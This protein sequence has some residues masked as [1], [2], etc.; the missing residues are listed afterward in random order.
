MVVA[1][2]VGRGGLRAAPRCTPPRTLS[3]IRGFL[4]IPCPAMSSCNSATASCPVQSINTC[5]DFAVDAP[6]ANSFGL[7]AECSDPGFD[8]TQATAPSIPAHAEFAERPPRSINILDTVAHIAEQALRDGALPMGVYG[9]VGGIA[10][11][12]VCGTATMSIPLLGPA[13]TMEAAPVCF[14]LGVGLGTATARL[15]TNLANQKEDPSAGVSQAFWV[16]ATAAAMG[17]ATP[18]LPAA[19]PLLQRMAHSFAAATTTGVSGDMIGT[20]IAEKSFDAGLRRGTDPTVW[21]GNAGMGLL[22]AGASEIAKAVFKTLLGSRAAAA[23]AAETL[24]TT[25]AQ[26]HAQP[27]TQTH[28]QPTIVPPVERPV[29]QEREWVA[30]GGASPTDP[31]ESF[32]PPWTRRDP[33]A[34]R[35]RPALQAIDESAPVSITGESQVA[36]PAIPGIRIPDDI[37]HFDMLTV[38]MVMAIERFQPQG[39]TGVEWQSFAGRL[40]GRIDGLM[41]EIQNT[42]PGSDDFLRRNVMLELFVNARK[43][44][45][46][47][48]VAPREFTAPEGFKWMQDLTGDEWMRR[49][50]DVNDLARKALR[51]VNERLEKTG[52]AAPIIELLAAKN[53][54]SMC[55]RYVSMAENRF[56]S[57][58]SEI[59]VSAP[60]HVEEIAMGVRAEYYEEGMALFTSVEKNSGSQAELNQFLSGLADLVTRAEA[61]KNILIKEPLTDGRALRKIADMLRPEFAKGMQIA[62]QNGWAIE[63]SLPPAPRTPGLTVMTFD[64]TP[65]LFSPGPL[66]GAPRTTPGSSSAV[67]TLKE[68]RDNVKWDSKA[69]ARLLGIPEPMYLNAEKNPQ[70]F[71]DKLKEW[72]PKLLELKPGDAPPPEVAP[73]IVNKAPTQAR[74][75]SK[76]EPKPKSEPDPNWMTPR[77]KPVKEARPTSGPFQA[78]TEADLAGMPAWTAGDV[79]DTLGGM[80]YEIK[81]QGN[82]YKIY[83]PGQSA[84]GIL[85]AREGSDSVVSKADVAKAL[86]G[87]KLKA[88]EILPLPLPKL[89]E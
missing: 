53:I 58:A 38:E 33:M 50:S 72:M 86:N 42:K 26:T 67:P 59:N 82:S 25:P 32:F 34:L 57:I 48:S 9:A 18:G 1:S 66:A 16:P 49:V 88:S 68:L 55:T 28:T 5:D 83:K 84:F 22:G 10:A 2:F 7:A 79:T 13:V 37:P 76:V 14:G 70:R 41:R 12:G 11:L 56:G 15:L 40:D 47:P 74:P 23:A 62:E 75:K 6:A 36:P 63:A 77:P 30:S 89:D 8:A 85:P 24:P 35:E 61:G 80:G 65:A 54:D 71:K 31:A 78:N 21:I 64:A 69:M 44:I 17:Y 3:I 39:A 4:D 20:G 81:P 19:A 60:L 29:V 43:S 46:E 73:A 27:P 51:S 45:S 52:T 87:L